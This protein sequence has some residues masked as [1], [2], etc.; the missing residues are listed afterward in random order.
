M[1]ADCSQGIENHVLIDIN[2]AERIGHADGDA[3]CIRRDSN[4]DRP[5][6]T[7][8]RS[9]DGLEKEPPHLAQTGFIVVVEYVP[10]V[11]RITGDTVGMTIGHGDLMHRAVNPDRAKRKGV[12]RFGMKQSDTSILGADDP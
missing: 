8:Y 4:A 3:V 1:G 2:A 6:A 10:E 5:G 9:A 11:V 12:S 7:K